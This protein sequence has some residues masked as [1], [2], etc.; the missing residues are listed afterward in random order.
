MLTDT[1]SAL[2]QG[3]RRN[4]VLHAHWTLQSTKDV[5]VQSISKTSVICFVVIQLYKFKCGNCADVILSTN[6]RRCFIC[7]L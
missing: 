3:Y 7:V 2:A 1:V 5:L 6:V 4:H